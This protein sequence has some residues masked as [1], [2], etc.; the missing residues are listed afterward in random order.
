MRRTTLRYG[1]RYDLSFVLWAVSSHYDYAAQRLSLEMPD[2]SYHNIDISH[3]T[4]RRLLPFVG[5]RL[6][7]Y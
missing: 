3:G 2:G 4:Y 7:L 6:D 5:T 1:R